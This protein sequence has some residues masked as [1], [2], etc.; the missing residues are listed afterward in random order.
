MGQFTKISVKEKNDTDIDYKSGLDIQG[1]P[2]KL[3][4]LE[5]TMNSIV[6]HDRDPVLSTSYLLTTNSGEK[7]LVGD[8]K[9]V[10]PEVPR[11]TSYMIT[12]I[13]HQINKQTKEKVL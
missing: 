11:F 4:E 5:E 6:Y 7:E 12:H 8:D 13:G 1:T 2:G 10:N 3:P 9:D